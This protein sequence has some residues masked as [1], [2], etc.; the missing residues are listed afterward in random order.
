M[1]GEMW[2]V[3]PQS[4]QGPAPIALSYIL[5]VTSKVG[6]EE[7]RKKETEEKKERHDNGKFV[8]LDMTC[9]S[10]RSLFCSSQRASGSE[11][12]AWVAPPGAT[13]GIS[14]AYKVHQFH[15]SS[16]PLLASWL[17]WAWLGLAAGQEISN[18]GS[19]TSS[20]DSSMEETRPTAQMRTV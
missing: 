6:G 2:K 14:I 18:S 19:P 3:F 7:R 15:S 17:G 5:G 1:V 13:R 9:L 11:K 8:P 20:K 4:I 12:N 16:H 10:G